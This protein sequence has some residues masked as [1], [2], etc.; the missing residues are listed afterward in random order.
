MNLDDVLKNIEK[1]FGEGAVMP[2]S[3]IEYPEVDVISTGSIALDYAIG[4][5][6]AFLGVPLGRLTIIWGPERSGKSSLCQH[7]CANAQKDELKAVYIDY[8]G[9]FDP[10]YAEA[11]GI[12]LDKLLFFE[13]WSRETGEIYPAEETWEIIDRLVRSGEIGV[14]ILDSLDAMM[15]RAELEGEY[16]ESHV[17]LKARSNAQAMRLLLGALKS[18][19]CALVLTGQRHYKI[20]RVFGNPET[21]AG[22]ETIKHSASLRLKMRHKEMHKDSAGDPT[23]I[24]SHV[25]VEKSKIAPP[26]HSADIHIKLGIGISKERELMDLGDQLGVYKKKGAYYYFQDDENYDAYGKDSAEEWLRENPEVTQWLEKQIRQTL[27]GAESSD[28]QEE[29]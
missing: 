29:T 9:S 1:D 5:K 2:F 26:F 15:P 4:A 18:H 23:A 22:G 8:E 17:G 13:P 19:K 14:I 16:G 27:S 12:D 21:M 7:I 28:E 11:C 3:Q 20:G 25:F 6:Q 10:D 24:D